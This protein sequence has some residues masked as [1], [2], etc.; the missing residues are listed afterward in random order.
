[1]PTLKVSPATALEAASEEAAAPDAVLP[2]EDAAPPQPVRASA[3]TAETAIAA[4]RKLRREIM[5]MVFIVVNSFPG[6]GGIKKTRSLC[7]TGLSNEKRPCPCVLSTRTGSVK[8]D[9]AVPPCLPCCERRASHGEPTLPC[10]VTEASVPSYW[11]T[12]PFARP[13]AAH[14][15][16]PRSRPFALPGLTADALCRFSS[17]SS[18]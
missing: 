2:V 4:F 15:T 1:M 8:Y 9:S 3:E 13:S 5:F 6:A 16:L 14:E 7:G 11:G 18:V 10:P 12:F 17:A